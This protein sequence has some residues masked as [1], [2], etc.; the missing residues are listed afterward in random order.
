MI[1]IRDPIH[2]ARRI[3]R[4]LL[5]SGGIILF[6]GLKTVV[7]DT[8]WGFELRCWV[9]SFRGYEGC[10]C[11]DCVAAFMPWPDPFPY[12]LA[13]CC[14]LLGYGDPESIA[15]REIIFSL[16]LLTLAL[17]GKPLLH[18]IINKL[19]YDPDRCHR[20]GYDLGGL[21]EPRCPECGSLPPPDPPAL[22]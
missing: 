13:I 7:F 5:W 20:C 8:W 12:E 21:P 15:L 10:M 3:R 9:Y 6:L 22:D 14:G 11:G 17:A 16:A 19:A 1:R 18:W 4:I 2:T